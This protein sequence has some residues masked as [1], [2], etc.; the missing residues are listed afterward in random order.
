MT[1]LVE[2]KN[3]V[4]NYSEIKSN[5][6]QGNHLNN[7]KKN[8][9]SNIEK[10]KKYKNQISLMSQLENANINEKKYDINKFQKSYFTTTL[11][12]LNQNDLS[13]IEGL[14][15]SAINFKDKTSG[16]IDQVN[17]DWVQFTTL[18]NQK[19]D[20]YLS[21]GKII[22]FQQIDKFQAILLKLKNVISKVLDKKEELKEIKEFITELDQQI[23]A[24]NLSE[25]QILFLEKI[26]KHECTL[27]DV[28]EEPDIL[29]W[30]KDYP[31]FQKRLKLTL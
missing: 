4:I 11:E 15:N 19:Y 2:L 31:D 30:I 13:V 23:L 17:Q 10:Y 6:S 7:L 1:K 9:Y 18:I 21:I 12:K 29:K 27:D 14:N 25:K 3:K 22:N 5:K 26:E 16:V 20:K 24:F 28:I 8:I